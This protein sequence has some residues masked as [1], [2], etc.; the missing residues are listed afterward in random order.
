M[1]SFKCYRT[2]V[3]NYS[4]KNETVVLGVGRR[5]VGAVLARE[6]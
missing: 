6:R 5:V 2:T 3:L 4:H 1:A